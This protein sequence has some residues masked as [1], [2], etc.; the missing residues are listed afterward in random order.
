[1]ITLENNNIKL[2][3]LEPTDVDILFK[4]EN[5]QSMWELSN[6][7]APFSKHL[8]EEYIKHS[9]LDIYQTRQLRLMIDYKSDGSQIPAGA[10]DIFDFDPFHQRAGLGILIDEK[11]R[12][13]GIASLSIELIISYCFNTLGLHQLYCNITADNKKSLQL[14][15]KHGFEMSGNKKEWIKSGKSW[16][17]EFF[18]QLLKANE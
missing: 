6:T 5:D 11:F 18:L 14:F 10:I 8:L 16:K 3:A 12:Q 7:I 17:D 9:H 2:R 4:W 1:M 13:R 15:T